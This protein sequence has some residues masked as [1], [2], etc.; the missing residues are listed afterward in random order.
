MKLLEEVVDPLPDGRLVDV[1]IGEHWTAVAAEVGGQLRCG[2]ASSVGKDRDKQGEMRARL[3]EAHKDHAKD[4]CSLAGWPDSIR[5]SVGIA[6]INALT[7]PRPRAWID[8]NAG[9]VIAQKGAGKRVAL[10][11]HF[12]FI[13]E[14]REQ[15]GDLK[16]LELRPREGDLP[17]SAAPEVIPQSEVV[18]ITG[19]AFVNG[20][21]EELLALCSP[22]AWVI[23]IGPSTPLSPA[24]FEHGVD[25]L[26]GSYVESVQ[27]VLQGVSA[28]KS[29]RQIHLLGVRLVTLAKPG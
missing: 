19:M 20:T 21:F 11:G 27:P 14:L 13:P 5:A 28:G 2:L 24:L 17:A 9:E 8:S 7:P 10:V 29:F 4:L 16:V 23:V 6:A 1:R 3:L 12:P 26:C 15:V 22:Q 25:Q 18:A